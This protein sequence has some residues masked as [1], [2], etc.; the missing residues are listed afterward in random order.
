V[1]AVAVD[2]GFHRDGAVEAPL[3][4][5]D[6]QDEV[7]FGRADGLEAVQVVVDEEE[8]FGGILVEQ[9]VF[10]GAQAM[11][12]A[13]AAGCVLALG[14]ARASGFLSIPAIGLDL[15]F[16]GSA[17]FV[18][19]IHIRVGGHV[20]PVSTLMLRAARDGQGTG[21]VQVIEGN[22]EEIFVKV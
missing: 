15:G 1:E 16:G 10:V 12:E 19:V 2:A 3:I 18:S 7:F 6:T 17:G 20:K 8:E 13:I 21:S 14:G 9:D 5:G 4:G 22:G 11:E